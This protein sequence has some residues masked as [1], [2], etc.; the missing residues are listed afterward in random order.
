[1]TEGDGV[2]LACKR[3]FFCTLEGF[4]VDRDAK[5][6]AN[7]VLAAIT[8]TNGSRLII[9][10]GEVL[11]ELLGQGA[12]PLDKLGFVFQKGEDS[13][14]QGCHSWVEAEDYT[15]FLAPFFISDLLLVI[16]F[17]EKGEGGAIHSG[18]R[19]HNV[20]DEFLPGFLIKILERFAAGFLVLLEVVV[21]A[22]GDAL[23]LLRAERKGIEKVVGALGVEGAVFFRDIE[24]G[25]FAPGD[26]DGFVPGK[27][28]GQPLIEPF[29]PFCR[30]DEEFNLHL[31]EFTGS[32]GEVAGVDFIAERLAD[33]GDSEREFFSGDLE[34]IFELHKHRLGRFGSEVGQ[35]SLVLDGPDV[36]FEH[37]VELAGL[38]EFAAAGVDPLAGF[39]GT[40][41][42]GDLIGAEAAFARFAIDHGVGEGGF[43]AAGLPYG[44]AHQDGTVHPDDIVTLLG[45]GFPPVV[46]QVPFQGD[47]EGTV[48]PGTV[49]APV[50][51]GRRKDKSPAFAEGHDLF[52]SVIRH[53][54]IFGF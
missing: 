51:F 47:P 21:G 53:K 17:T 2:F 22:V 35:I 30:G 43:V 25:D 31:L 13:R 32:E 26:A 37:Q 49:Q 20:R 44:A 6:G 10:N 42:G 24:D 41:G 9:E 18:T 46:F 3:A 23:E 45:H 39:L 28:V 15:G 14:L 34:D 36:R 38:G 7:L 5:G 52:H 40:G 8:P 12:G 11:A 29:L 16:S 19:F 33:L 27:A 4:E 1:M 48:V 54:V 50:D